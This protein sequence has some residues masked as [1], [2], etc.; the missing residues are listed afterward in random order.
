MLDQPHA[1]TRAAANDEIRAFLKIREELMQSGLTGQLSQL[2]K[3]YLESGTLSFAFD[4]SQLDALFATVDAD[5]YRIYFAADSY[6]NPTVVIIPHDSGAA[7]PKNKLS[8]SAGPGQQYPKF[9]GTGYNSTNFD[10]ANE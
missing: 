7:A 8:N 4:K 9:E 2:A 3:T 6:G 1:I 10:I 5:A